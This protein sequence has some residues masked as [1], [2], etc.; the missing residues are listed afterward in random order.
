M[1]LKY[2]QHKQQYFSCARK[3]C[4]DQEI[5]NIVASTLLITFFLL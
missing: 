2:I 3:K 1:R 5:K 4:L